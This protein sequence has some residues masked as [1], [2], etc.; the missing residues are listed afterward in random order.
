MGHSRK[1]GPGTPERATS[2]AFS[3][4]GTSSR[5]VEAEAA[6]LTWGWTRGIWS[7]SW[8]APRPLSRVAA[9]P[10]RSTSAR[11]RELGVLDRGD[12]VGDA[13][14]GGDRR[15]AG[16]PG[17]AEDRVGGEDGVHLMADVHHPDAAVLGAHEDGRDVP[18]AEGEEEPHPALHQ[19]RSDPV[20]AV[21][22]GSSFRSIQNVPV[23]REAGEGPRHHGFGA[24]QDLDVDLGFPAVRRLDA[25]PRL[26]PLPHRH[27]LEEPRL[28]APQHHVGIVHR[29]HG[30]VVRETED[31]PAMDQ[32]ALVRG[33]LREGGEDGG[34]APR[35]QLQRLAD[36]AAVD[37][38]VG[39]GEGGGHGRGL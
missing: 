13:G 21:H 39:V 9:E 14:A 11:L 24:P 15:H 35:A 26:Q 16:D 29:Q 37:A 28:R 1:T 4:I 31:E 12:R 30:R 20:A 25:R 3:S 18:A 36:E 19:H 32:P 2:K 27:R 5:T 22:R 34:G 23:Q 17:E 8:S 7:M 6:H 10:P 38:E 33:H